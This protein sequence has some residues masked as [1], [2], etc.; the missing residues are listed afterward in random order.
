MEGCRVPTEPMG[1]LDILGECVDVT[2]LDRGRGFAY[3]SRPPAFANLEDLDERAGARARRVLFRRRAVLPE[4]KLLRLRNA[5]VSERGAVTTE[6]GRQ[7]VETLRHGNPVMVHEPPGAEIADFAV[8]LR[9]PGDRNFG[10]WLIELCA[11]VHE[12][13]K[14]HPAE[15]WKLAIPRYPADRQALR[16]RSLEWLGIGEDR[17]LWIEDG[18]T[19]FRDLAFVTSNSVHSHTHEPAGLRSVRDA[20]LR[21]VG[22]V[23]GGRRLYVGRGG[24][25]RRALLNEAEILALCE[26]HGFESVRPETLSLD[27]QVRLFASAELIVGV[28]GAALTNIL[29]APQGCKILSLNPNL[30]P[31][32]FFWDIANILSQEFSYVF[33]PAL[34]P[35][36]GV[37]SSFQVDAGLVARWLRERVG[38][39]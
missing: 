10:H 16:R 29:F 19:R 18:T 32:F 11:R 21:A 37:H 38:T 6:G 4:A 8:L 33:G 7:I 35:D 17:I 25:S 30:G 12:F 13:R 27:D 15:D 39:A 22:S 31:E 34:D 28:S 26:G 14:I 2:D 9:K 36:R 20:A 24:A 23:A 1:F 3:E 5:R